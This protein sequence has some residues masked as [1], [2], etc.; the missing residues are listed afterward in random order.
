MIPGEAQDFGSC[1]LEVQ[2]RAIEPRLDV[3]GDIART[4]FYVD[5]AY[6]GRDINSR[7]KRKHFEAWDKEHPV[8][9][10]SRRS[11]R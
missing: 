10:S 3:L 9:S 4:Y 5:A 6:P 11:W 1:G 8:Q 2:E 7:Q